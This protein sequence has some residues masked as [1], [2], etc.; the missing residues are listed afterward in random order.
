ML[1]EPLSSLYSIGP[2]GA[3]GVKRQ[4]LLLAFDTAARWT[5]GK[6]AGSSG[7]KAL[8]KPYCA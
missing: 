5:D 8:P 6:T 1:D 4:M 3:Q 7:A 2:S